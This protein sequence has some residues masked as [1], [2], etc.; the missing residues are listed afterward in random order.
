MGAEVAKE[1]S[2]QRRRRFVVLRR[3][4]RFTVL[5]LVIFPRVRID[6]KWQTTV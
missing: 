3:R 2:K 1:N 5:Y 6:K 4:R